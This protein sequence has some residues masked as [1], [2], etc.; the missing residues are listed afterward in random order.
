M[1]LVGV[2][3]FACELPTHAR[4]FDTAAVTVD[5]GITCPS[6]QTL[7]IAAD[8]TETCSDLT[9]DPSNCGGCGVACPATQSCLAGDAG[10][11]CGCGGSTQLCA[12]ACLDLSSNPTHCGSC[13]TACGADTICAGG[14]CVTT[15]QNG[16]TNCSD[17]CTNVSI[18]ST[19]CGECNHACNAGTICSAAAC[20]VNDGGCGTGLTSC[21]D[22]G[23]ADLTQDSKNCGRCGVSCG[24]G[25]GCVDA[26]CECTNGLTDCNGSCSACPVGGSC[27]GTT[28]ACAPGFSPTTTTPAECCSTGTT[29]YPGRDMCCSKSGTYCCAVGMYL[30]QSVAATVP[31]VCAPTSEDCF[32]A[33]DTIPAT[34]YK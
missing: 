33:A 15:C 18:D 32:I 9:D 14:T 1:A 29:F 22:A 30:C 23:C 28:C 31:P 21:F 25:Q 27:Q 2:L 6:S 20:V 5:G 10:P 11:T 34:V 16:Q 13:D 4:D 3:G 12:G 17:S 7:C 24:S 26:G 8:G 19:H